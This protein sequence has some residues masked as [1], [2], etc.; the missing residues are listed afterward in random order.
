[1]TDTNRTQLSYIEESTRGTTPAGNFKILNHAG[2]SLA[3]TAQTTQSNI[4]RADRN[5]KNMI[6][7]DITQA[8]GI[9]TEMG[10][11]FND[12]FYESAFSSDF[13]SQISL[14]GTTFSI[15]ASG[16]PITLDDSGN[17]LGG[18]K[19]NDVIMVLGYTSAGAVCNGAYIVGGNTAA[20]SVDAIPVGHTPITTAAGATV[21]ITTTRL[22]NAVTPKTF[23][24][25]EYNALSGIYRAWLGSQVDGLTLSFGATSI[26]TANF[27]F[28]GKEEPK[29]SATIGDGYDA[30]ST[31]SVIDPNTGYLGTFLSVNGAAL[32]SSTACV[33]AVTY[34]FANNSRREKGLNCVTFGDGNFVVTVNV[35]LVFANK[36][37]YDAF[38]DNSYIS[39]ASVVVD[40]SNQGFGVVVPKVEGLGMTAAVPG[41]NQTVTATVTGQGVLATVG[42]DNYTAL[43]SKLG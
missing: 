41:P 42:S 26:P 33:T 19:P 8:G 12:E 32:A 20:S 9:N 27:T 24:I 10:H 18:L 1:M 22:T 21:T 6:R 5:V 17:G 23:S 34:N 40:E 37:I 15:D 30:A 38:L 11:E 36:D 3:S 2:H 35:T 39:L 28:M 7:T 14:S 13:A 25:E 16:S 29:I 31:N 4:I 43:L